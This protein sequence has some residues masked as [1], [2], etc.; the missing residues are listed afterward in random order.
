MGCPHQAVA[1]GNY[2][3]EQEDCQV[4]FDLCS[5]MPQSFPSEQL[6][7]AVF[8][9]ILGRYLDDPLTG[10][11]P[12][13]VMSEAVPDGCIAIYKKGCVA[14]LY[15]EEIKLEIG[16]LGDP[17]FQGQR[18][19]QLFLTEKSLGPVVQRSV[20]PVL[21]VELVGP[22]LRVSLLASPKDGVVV[23]E[24]VTPFL[25]LFNMSSSQPDHMTRVAR[26]LRALQRGVRL[27]RAEYEGLIDSLPAEPL[28]AGGG[29]ASY[30]SAGPWLPERDASLQLPYPLRPGSGFR[31]VEAHAAAARDPTKLLYVAEQEESGRK[32]VVKFAPS[33]SE[34]AT[35]IHRAWAAADLAPPLLEERRLPC[36]MTML[37][38]ERL[39]QEDGWTLFYDLEPE[40]KRELS[41]QVLDALARAHSVNVD[42]EGVA[43]HA[44][45][46]QANVMVKMSEGGDG[47]GGGQT[48]AGRGGRARSRRRQT[49][50][51]RAQAL[52][53]RF[54]DF[55]WS[56]LVGRAP[57]PPFMRERLP[58]YS[59][60]RQ[61]TQE[62]DRALWQHELERGDK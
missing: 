56:G 5:Q 36:G 8:H 40:A 37:V 58:G 6:R 24:P 42:G 49:P 43:V 33:L 28:P 59:T 45:M 57:L 26:V 18:Y 35:R 15:I 48:P 25:H 12:N 52:Q 60:G 21:L 14:P 20:L 2:P 27:L 19:Y 50:A 3:L 38:M 62:Y 31:N 61:A 30:A 51:G 22:H 39:T 32:V 55:D 44:D 46:R 34:D 4:A 16:S 23:C 29:S 53:V 9:A 13:K 47:A 7:E 41:Q 11:F 1:G 10:R 17:Y 54:L